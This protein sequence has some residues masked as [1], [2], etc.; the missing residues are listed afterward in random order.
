MTPSLAYGHDVHFQEVAMTKFRFTLFAAAVLV[1]ASSAMADTFVRVTL[2]DTGAVSDLSQSM[3]L[4]MGMNGDMKKATMSI[5]INPKSV[6]HGK[7]KFYVTNGSSKVIHEMILSP[8]KDVNSPLPYMVKD[9]KVDEE[10]SVHLGEVSELD[11]GKSGALTVD[12]KPG[13]YIL[14]CNITGH[15]MSGMWTLIDVH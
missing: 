3:G 13:K 4:G 5:D 1:S 2:R 15:Y 6:P 7:V 11:P 10:G 12:V 9:N 14:Y 8:V